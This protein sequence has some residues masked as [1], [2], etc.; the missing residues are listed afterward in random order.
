MIGFSLG[1]SNWLISI[2]WLP[3]F[4]FLHWIHWWS[5]WTFKIIGKLPTISKWAQHT[6]LTWCVWI[7]GYLFF[8]WFWIAKFMINSY[9]F[10]E[11]KFKMVMECTWSRHRAPCLRCWYPKHL[12]WSV[13]QTG[14]FWFI[15]ILLC[16]FLIC[17][18]WFLDAAI[19]SDIFTLWRNSI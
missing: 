10:M 4:A 12:L 5:F 8:H 13:I 19:V 1:N 11:L 3:N 18:I 16:P 15:S 17:Q 7:F 14:Q 9:S 6:E 2:Q